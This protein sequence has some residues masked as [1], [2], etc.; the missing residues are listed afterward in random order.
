M[1][2]AF[3]N[4]VNQFPY[5]SIA[6]KNWV[7]GYFISERNNIPITLYHTPP[8]KIELPS[9]MI[10]KLNYF[11]RDFS[12]FAREKEVTPW[13]V[14]MPCKRRVLHGF[15]QFNNNV[16]LK[17]KNWLPSDLPDLISG[18]SE[19]YG[20]NF[21]DL[22]FALVRET[23]V[24][25]TLLYNSIYDSHINALGSKVIAEEIARNF[26]AAMNEHQNLTAGSGKR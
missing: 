19:N 5:N 14:F 20:I 2:N 10:M 23:E 9:D 12:V 4:L 15:I 22:T 18:L 26:L 8:G 17:M 21:I 16:D 7:T 25:G 6:S 13:L 11:F 3:H 24:K 1:L